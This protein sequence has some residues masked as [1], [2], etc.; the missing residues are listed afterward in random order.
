MLLAAGLEQAH[1]L[2]DTPRTNIGSTLGGV[3]PAQPTLAIELRERL[4]RRPRRGPFIE[5]F[6]DIG[7][8]VTELRAFRPDLDGDLLPI[9]EQSRTGR[10]A[11]ALDQPSGISEYQRAAK[12]GPLDGS[13]HVVAIAP[14]PHIA[15]IEWEWD[16]HTVAGAGGPRL[17]PANGVIGHEATSLN[18]GR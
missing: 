16:L 5:R 1:H 12:P 14:S 17:K 10:L 4:E 2:G 13:C 18:G 3:D 6:G 8:K 11:S 7:C 15:W 9:L